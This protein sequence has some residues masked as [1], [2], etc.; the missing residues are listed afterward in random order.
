MKEYLTDMISS[1][2]WLIRIDS[3][4]SEAKP[5]KPFGEGCAM[6]LEYALSLCKSFGFNTFNDENYAGHADIGEG[7]LF[8]ILGHLDTVPH[9]NDWDYPPCGGVIDNGRLYGRGAQDDK[10][11]MIAC[12]YA[13]K[14][15]L[16]E[17]YK[18]KKKIR[19]IFGCNEESG[20][21]GIDHY[22]KTQEMPK[23]GF[24][25]DADF[26]VINC[27]KGVSYYKLCC[28]LPEKVLSI[29]GGDRANMVPD[30]AEAKISDNIEIPS[31]CTIKAEGSKYLLTATGVSAHGSS[32]D[33]GDNAL[34]KI[35]KNLAKLYSGV[36]ETI[37]KKLCCTDGSKCGIKIS[38]E[39]SG[40][41][42][43]NLGKA[44]TDGNKL[45]LEIDTRQPISY[46]KEDVMEMLKKE[47]PE[48]EVTQGA[49]H[50][51]L[52]VDENDNLVQSMLKA[53]NKVTGEEA[54]PITI[55]GGTYARALPLGV[56]FGPIFPNSESTIHCKNENIK[57]DEFLKTAEIYYE[58]MKSLCF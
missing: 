46:K 8:G 58:A 53:Y 9:G 3:V 32:P 26:P 36:F 1:L 50:D 28:D 22:F 17:G 51:P 14:A 38:D 29:K 43:M 21:K 33:K 11:P 30:Y 37:Y 47:I 31:E 5:N 15:L 7:E 56:A 16:D 55:G 40:D 44:Y 2:Q 45:Y 34:W 27:E 24:S 6:A 54:K 18:P 39:K 13:V 12:L 57:I 49:F 19:F 25:P 20:W 41:L 48:F 10:G 23:S 52:Y 35:F 42:T 4:Q